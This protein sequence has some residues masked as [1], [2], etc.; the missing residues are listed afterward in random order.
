MLLYHEGTLTFFTINYY[1]TLLSRLPVNYGEQAKL[2]VGLEEIRLHQ[3]YNYFL[4]YSL[5]NFII[6]LFIF[7]IFKTNHFLLFIF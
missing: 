6:V 4:K 3:V 7:I 1:L 5:K 2:K